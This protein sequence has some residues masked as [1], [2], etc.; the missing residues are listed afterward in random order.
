MPGSAFYNIPVTWL[1]KGRL[2]LTVLEKSLSALVDRHETLRTVFQTAEDAPSQVILEP[3]KLPIDFIDLMHIPE[4]DRYA[5]F[6]Q[7]LDVDL[8]VQ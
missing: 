3:G 7:F 8:S 5:E 2:N 1:L 6:Q 4:V